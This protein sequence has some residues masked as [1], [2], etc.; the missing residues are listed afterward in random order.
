MDKFVVYDY[1]G[2]VKAEA[3]MESLEKEVARVQEIVNASASII[4][5]NIYETDDQT[6]VDYAKIPRV[7]RVRFGLL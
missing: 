7:N 3:S 2:T 6:G 5:A 1:Y 4:G